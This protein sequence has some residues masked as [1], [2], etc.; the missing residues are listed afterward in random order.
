MEMDGSF[1]IVV[2]DGDYGYG[3]NGSDY[4]FKDY[5]AEYDSFVEGLKEFIEWSAGSDTKVVLTY[6]PQKAKSK[7]KAKNS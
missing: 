7:K 4:G 1:K 3:A 2:K 6:K 5:V